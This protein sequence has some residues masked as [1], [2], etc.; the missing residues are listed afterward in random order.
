MTDGILTLSDDPVPRDLHLSSIAGNAPEGHN[1]RVEQANFDLKPELFPVHSP[2]LREYF[3]V[4]IPPFT[5]MLKFN[6]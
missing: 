6:G 1:S 3:L 2:L 5:Y 4:S